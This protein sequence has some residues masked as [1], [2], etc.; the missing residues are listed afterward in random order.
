MAD[1]VNITKDTSTR[2][3]PELDLHRLR[4]LHE[5]LRNSSPDYRATLSAQ[6]RAEIDATLNDNLAAIDY[7]IAR[8][9]DAPENSVPCDIFNFSHGE[10]TDRTMSKLGGLPY[11]PAARPWPKNWRGKPL[12]FLGQINFRDS[13]DIV[14]EL[15]GEILAMFVNAHNHVTSFWLNPTDEPLIAQDDI[16]PNQRLFGP[17]YGVIHRTYDIP[18]KSLA[19]EV[20]VNSNVESFL[21]DLKLGGRPWGHADSDSGRAPFLFQM[22]SPSEYEEFDNGEIGITMTWRSCKDWYWPFSQRAKEGTQTFEL[23]WWAAHLKPSGMLRWS[24]V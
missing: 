5:S 15:P 17:R 20:G 11:W 2:F 16:P 8:D 24:W 14:G 12:P 23:Y 13:K 18:G 9:H 21:F 3:H 7:V 1:F 6:I 22:K 4:T 10:T 19:E